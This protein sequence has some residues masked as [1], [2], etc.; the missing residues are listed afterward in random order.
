MGIAAQSGCVTLILRD[1]QYPNGHNTKVGGLAD[2]LEQG[3][4]TNLN[5]SVTL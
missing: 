1:I 2:C 5:I 3:G 4:W